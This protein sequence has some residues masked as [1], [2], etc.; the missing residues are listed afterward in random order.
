MKLFKLLPLFILLCNVTW[1]QDNDND[2]DADDDESVGGFYYGDG[3]DET[4]HDTAQYLDLPTSYNAPKKYVIAAITVSGVKYYNTDQILALSGLSIGDTISIPAESNAIAMK[5]LWAN[6]MFSNVKLRATKIEANK[7]WL[8]IY[9]RER[10]RIVAYYF[11]GIKKGDMEDIG[12]KIGLQRGA[13]YSEYIENRTI[14]IIKRFYAEKGYRNA[15][16]KP[17]YAVDSVIGNGLR[18]KFVI[19]KGKK[20]RIKE[21]EFEG[22]KEVSARQLR[23]QQMKVQRF[24]WYTFWRSSKYLDKE[25]DEDKLKLIE[26]FQE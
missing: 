7:I 19:D 16:I 24:R 3:D 10:Y 26:Y 23:Q 4:A 21:F 6:G 15:K 9:L 17:Q 5:K 1:A 8:D 18:V 22:N 12:A 20:V 13:E 11:E 14:D 2:T 25:L